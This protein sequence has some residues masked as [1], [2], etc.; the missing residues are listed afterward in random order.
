MNYEGNF[1]VI[2][3]LYLFGYLLFTWCKAY[4]LCKL[5]K[6]LFFIV[7]VYVAIGICV[8]YILLNKYCRK[9]MDDNLYFN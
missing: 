8:L 4:V 6:E 9:L 7:A 5:I 1:L 2:N 3:S